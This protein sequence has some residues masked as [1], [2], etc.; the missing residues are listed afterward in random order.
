MFEEMLPATLVF[1]QSYK[2][3]LCINSIA[4]SSHRGLTLIVLSAEQSCVTKKISASNFWHYSP[5]WKHIK[6]L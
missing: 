6:F 5:G 4:T 2:I 3:T 1:S